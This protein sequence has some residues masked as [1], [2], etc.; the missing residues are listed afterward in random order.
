MSEGIKLYF[1]RE[2]G[3]LEIES[4]TEEVS[5]MFYSHRV[6]FSS[7][8]S[9]IDSPTWCDG[10]E[11]RKQLLWNRSRASRTTCRNASYELIRSNR[12]EQKKHLLWKPRMS[13]SSD[14][15]FMAWS[16]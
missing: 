6:K 3:I 16:E 12:E 2:G 5:V 14:S 1:W 13:C 8:G 10:M 9:G 4:E 15:D 7:A 11:Q